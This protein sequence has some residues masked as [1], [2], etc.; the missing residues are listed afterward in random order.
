MVQCSPEM[1]QHQTGKRPRRK[2]V[3]RPRGKGLKDRQR[4]IPEQYKGQS[5]VSF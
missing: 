2:P 3:R 1:Q 5:Q 4:R